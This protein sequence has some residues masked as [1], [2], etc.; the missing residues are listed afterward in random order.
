[1]GKTVTYFVINYQEEHYSGTYVENMHIRYGSNAQSCN[2]AGFRVEYPNSTI[3]CHST[4]FPAIVAVERSHDATASLTTVE[5]VFWIR[6]LPMHTS[7]AQ[8]RT[9]TPVKP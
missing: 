3:G 7:V 6:L 1:M 4:L 5:E 8:S 2:A 9:P